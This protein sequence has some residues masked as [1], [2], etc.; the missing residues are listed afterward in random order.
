VTVGADRD[1]PAG[2]F[3]RGRGATD[4]E[5]DRLCMSGLSHGRDRFLLRSD[6]LRRAGDGACE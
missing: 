6:G 4:A 5:S 2:D 3:F 1:I